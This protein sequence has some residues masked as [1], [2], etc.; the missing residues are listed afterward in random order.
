MSMRNSKLPAAKQLALSRY[1]STN[2]SL[3]HWGLSL[4]K[5]IQQQASAAIEQAKEFEMILET[6]GKFPGALQ[7]LS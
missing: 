4:K 6:G 5:S 7:G 2:C 1:I 3:L